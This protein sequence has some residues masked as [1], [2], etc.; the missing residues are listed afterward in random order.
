MV[1]AKT[2]KLKKLRTS[3]GLS[4]NGLATKSGVCASTLSYI[5]KGRPAKET[6]AYDIATA[7]GVNIFDVFEIVEENAPKGKTG[8]HYKQV[9]K[10]QKITLRVTKEKEEKL[11]KIA[12]EQGRSVSDLINFLIDKGLK[13]TNGTNEQPKTVE[14]LAS[15]ESMLDSLNTKNEELVKELRRK[16]TKS[17]HNPAD[18]NEYMDKIANEAI[19]AASKIR[20]TIV[21]DLYTEMVSN[22]RRELLNESSK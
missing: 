20:V 14:S 1:K 2:D 17:S 19:E 9:R 16:Y 10:S 5:E 7:L 6:T 4:S 8:N 12:K 3:L 18:L 13:E 11:Q 21:R 22:T 15:I